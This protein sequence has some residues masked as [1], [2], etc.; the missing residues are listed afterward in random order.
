[1]QFKDGEGRF[2]GSWIWWSQVSLSTKSLISDMRFRAF[3]IGHMYQIL[4]LWGKKKTQSPIIYKYS[5][6]RKTR[7]ARE[8]ERRKGSGVPCFWLRVV[9]GVGAG[10]RGTWTWHMVSHM[11]SSLAPEGLLYKIPLEFQ[12]P[13]Q[14][15]HQ[16]GLMQAGHLFGAH[17]GQSCSVASCLFP[18]GTAQ[19][20]GHWQTHQPSKGF[21]GG[22]SCPS[23]GT[24]S[25]SN[26]GS[27]PSVDKEMPEDQVI[28]WWR[29]LT[30]LRIYICSSS[31]SSIPFI[32][33]TNRY[34][35]PCQLQGLLQGLDSF[36]EKL[37]VDP[38]RKP[39]GVSVWTPLML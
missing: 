13:P 26:H 18:E 19:S 3:H 6:T 27:Q 32:H 2:S 22:H 11:I 37:V 35:T 21:S 33:S 8:E 20:S 36:L 4:C 23:E 31:H 17:R 28:N 34:S 7:P 15:N 16:Q 10:A 25:T 12:L 1:M 24:L 38:Q 9:V 39:H 5:L 30:M 14:I 29:W